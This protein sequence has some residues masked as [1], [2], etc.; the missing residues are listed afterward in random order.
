MGV[1]EGLEEARRLA[2]EDWRVDVS[3][4]WPVRKRL[5]EL[6]SC[7]DVMVRDYVREHVYRLRREVLAAELVRDL[8]K[9][10]FGMGRHPGRIAYAV[11]RSIQRVPAVDCYSYADSRV[12]SWGM[13]AARACGLP[14][15]L[16]VRLIFL[17][18]D[19][20]CRLETRLLH[21]GRDQVMHVDTVSSPANVAHRLAG[22]AHGLLCAVERFLDAPPAP[23]RNTSAEEDWVGLLQACRQLE[24]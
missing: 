7:R 3:R 23:S 22:Y 16:G 11:A 10:L 4:S 19:E 17:G 14:A 21:P 24:G 9:S 15:G 6:L 13:V 8:D 18:V 2:H 20:R 12:G 5:G 1:F